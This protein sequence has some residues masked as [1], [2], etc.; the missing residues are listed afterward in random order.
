M[1]K[2]K[3]RRL[4]E[5]EDGRGKEGRRREEGGKTQGKDVGREQAS[6]DEEASFPAP[7]IGRLSIYPLP[8]LLLIPET[9]HCTMASNGRGFD[10]P[11]SRSV[12]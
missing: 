8:F 11:L 12:M 5:E 6:M 3:R 4:E 7:S 1:P 9:G 10:A 2:K